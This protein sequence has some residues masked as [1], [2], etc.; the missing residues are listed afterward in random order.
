VKHGAIQK[1]KQCSIEG[2][3]NQASGRGM[4]NRHRGNAVYDA[5]TAL[6][7]GSAFS[8]TAASFSDHKPG[9]ASDQVP[10]N[11]IIRGEE[12]SN[13]CLLSNQKGHL[14]PATSPLPC[15]DS[16]LLLL[17]GVRDFLFQ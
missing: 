3:K 10:A 8:E 5:S 6:F 14:T 16:Y 4:C 1:R 15:D 11:V 2:C 17:P 13:L 9:A 7:D 12:C